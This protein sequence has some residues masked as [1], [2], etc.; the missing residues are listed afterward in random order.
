MSKT[1]ETTAKA[2]F[3]PQAKAS[4][5]QVIAVSTHFSKLKKC[6]KDLAIGTFRGYLLNK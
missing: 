4:Y 5:K 2:D 6:P 3:N 1:I